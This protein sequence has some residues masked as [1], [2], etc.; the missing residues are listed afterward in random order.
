MM[1]SGTPIRS[2]IRNHEAEVRLMRG[3]SGR[4]CIN[5]ASIAAHIATTPTDVAQIGTSFVGVD[6]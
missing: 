6:V 5:T 1:P 2:T 3:H 4:V